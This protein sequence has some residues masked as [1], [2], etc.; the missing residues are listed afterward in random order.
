VRNPASKLESSQLAD[1]DLIQVTSRQWRVQQDEVSSLRSVLDLRHGELQELRLKNSMLERSLEGLDASQKKASTYKARVED[2]ELQLKLKKDEESRFSTMNQSLIESLHNESQCNKR[3]TQVNEELAWK[4]KMKTSD[5]NSHS[6]TPV[7][8]S[9]FKHT[10]LPSADTTMTSLQDSEP[11]EP[12]KSKSSADV[13]AELSNSSM[14]TSSYLERS[15]SVAWMYHMGDET[16]SDTIP[17]N[18]LK[19]SAS[20][21]R[22]NSP[23]S[24]GIGSPVRTQASPR[25][26]PKHHCYIAS[27][28]GDATKVT[29]RAPLAN[30][31][32]TKQDNSPLSSWTDPSDDGFIFTEVTG[33][34]LHYK[35][36]HLMTSSD[37]GFNF[38]EVSG[39]TLHFKDSSEARTSSSSESHKMFS[40]MLPS[41]ESV[42]VANE[43]ET[44][45]VLPLVPLTGSKSS[46]LALMAAQIPPVPKDAGGELVERF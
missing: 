37:D 12:L 25:N 41:S 3:L 17:K 30:S 21:K 33:V 9:E 28:D 26:R 35:D 7:P 23:K 20:F 39:A 43:G 11:S 6:E 16:S 45:T 42:L 38:T 13:C 1:T 18:L 5:P 46:E 24:V 36:F 44:E 32:P 34:S 4:L 19:K 31:T 10:S 22:V 27:P 2:L 14:L 40:M 29:Y 8:V 15:E